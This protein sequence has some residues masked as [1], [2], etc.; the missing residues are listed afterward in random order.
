[1]NRSKYEMFCWT[2]LFT[3]VVLSIVGAVPWWVTT[4]Y[5]ILLALLL[6][7]W[8]WALRRGLAMFQQRYHLA[9]DTIRESCT[10]DVARLWAFHDDE[11]EQS[12]RFD[13]DDDDDDGDGEHVRAE[14]QP[15]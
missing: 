8:I 2:S 10:P 1:M 9:A 4:T 12:Y 15:V 3:L 11:I 13:D 14:P 6:R 7:I 5:A